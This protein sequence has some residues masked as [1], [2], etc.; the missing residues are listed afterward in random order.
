MR[1]PL[2]SEDAAFR[3]VLGTIAYLAP[4]VIASWIATW[5]GLVVFAVASATVVV[6]LRR[7][8]RS[9]VGTPAVGE[10]A[11][12]EDTRRI[13]VVVDRV[14]AGPRLRE[15]VVDL[16]TGGAEDVLLVWARSGPSG[17]GDRERLEGAVEE[18]R[19]SG[20]NVRG[21]LFSGSRSNA[22]EAMV[23]RYA[24]DA[25]VIAGRSDEGPAT[26]PELD[27]TLRARFGDAITYVSDGEP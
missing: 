23:R 5:L 14:P 9:R 3:L 11:A 20:L 10:R 16:A 21:E 19:A 24:A 27:P 18:L 1:N 26:R 22:A 8:G 4:V 25:L 13:L 2:V 6:V 15:T 7:K 12:V 17:E